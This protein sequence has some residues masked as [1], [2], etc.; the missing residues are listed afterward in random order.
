MTL[1]RQTQ[2][3]APIAITPRRSIGGIY[4]QIVVEEQHTD[5]LCITDYPTESGASMSDHAFKKP[6]RVSIAA[7]VSATHEDVNLFYQKLL[8]LQEKCEPFEIITG[9]RRYT[10]ML[11]ET[12]AV[13]T[14]K[15]KENSLWFHAT[16]KRIRIVGVKTTSL[17]PVERQTLPNSTASPK[18][19]GTITPKPVENESAASKIFELF[20][21]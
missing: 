9:K 19:G 13:P 5:S 14:D 2:T 3:D 10:D 20:R 8:E 16:C 4:P 11:V 12:L 6:E 1:N 15:T 17:P 21:N 7:G 18:D